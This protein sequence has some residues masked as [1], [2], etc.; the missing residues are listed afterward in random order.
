MKTLVVLCTLLS[1]IFASPLS[2]KS[3]LV[4]DFYNPP[5]GYESAKLGEILKLRK[6][7]RQNKQFVY[8][9]GG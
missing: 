8:P 1:I 3:P 7:A 9:C 6:N 5:R 2:L 4:D